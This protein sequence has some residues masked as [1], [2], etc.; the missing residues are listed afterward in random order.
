MERLSLTYGRHDDRRHRDGSS[1]SQA[2][3]GRCQRC[4]ARAHIIDD[5]YRRRAV[6]GKGQIR[7]PQSLDTGR[8]RL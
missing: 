6:I 1:R 7:P 4:P 3:S 2:S 8:S 5:Q